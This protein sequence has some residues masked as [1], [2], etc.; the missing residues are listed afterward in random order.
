[1]MNPYNSEEGQAVARIAPKLPWIA[2]LS[3]FAILVLGFLA[4]WFF[5]KRTTGMP[6]RYSTYT[7]DS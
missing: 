2:F 7:I 4:V 6:R 1:M 5:A 3:A